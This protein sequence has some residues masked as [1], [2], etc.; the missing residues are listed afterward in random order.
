MLLNYVNIN[1]KKYVKSIYKILNDKIVLYER[2]I[3]HN[4]YSSSNNFLTIEE[5]FFYN[6][7]EDIKNIKFSIKFE[8]TDIKVIR[9]FY[10]KRNNNRLMLKTFWKLIFLKIDYKKIFSNIVYI[11]G[12]LENVYKLNRYFYMDSKQNI[13][14]IKDIALYLIVKKIVLLIINI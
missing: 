5:K 4:T 6:F 1:Y 3:D 14:N 9:L 11:M 2:I 12:E 7:N 10:N 8:M 13:L